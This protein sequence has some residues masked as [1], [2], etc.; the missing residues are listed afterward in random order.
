MPLL[1]KRV[2]SKGVTFDNWFVNSPVCC[3]SRANVLTGRYAHNT[4]FTDVFPP[5]G[6]YA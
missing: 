3:P 4:N 6:A 5:H 1:N 2:I